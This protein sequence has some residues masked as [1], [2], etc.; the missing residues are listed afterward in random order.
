MNAAAKIEVMDW[1]KRSA[2][3]WLSNMGFG[4][5]LQN[6]LFQQIRWHF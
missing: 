1:S 6:R 4:F 3:Q 2:H 5:G